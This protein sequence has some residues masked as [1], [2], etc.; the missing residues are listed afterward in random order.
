MR[1]GFVT[2]LLDR[3][4]PLRG[5]GGGSGSRGLQQRLDARVVAALEQILEAEALPI[6]V[7]RGEGDGAAARAVHGEDVALRR[8]ADDLDLVP[9]AG[10][11]VGDRDVVVLAPE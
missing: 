10:A 6:A 4:V 3:G 2:A 9:G 1:H 5:F 8:V 7:D 11:D